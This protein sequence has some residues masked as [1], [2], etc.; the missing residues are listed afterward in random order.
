[1]TLA[2]LPAPRAA[3]AVATIAGDLYVVGGRAAVIGT[4]GS[5]TQPFANLW[6]YEVAADRW[7]ERAPLP[8]ALSGAA[9]I[10]VGDS[11]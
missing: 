3:A 7:Q 8:V 1:Q 4:F 10:G 5:A 6:R 11:L 9:A 2:A